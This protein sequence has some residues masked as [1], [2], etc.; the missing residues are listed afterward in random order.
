ME[1]IKL[2]WKPL[3]SVLSNLM[4]STSEESNLQ[5]LL[6]SYQ[7][8]IGVCGSVSLKG[9]AG[10]LPYEARDAFLESLCSFCLTQVAQQD[11]SATQGTRVTTQNSS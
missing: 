9:T 3:L 5:M 2:T 10:N 11:K 4:K 6:N 8:F 7:N 1:L